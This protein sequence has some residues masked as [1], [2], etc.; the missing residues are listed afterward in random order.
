MGTVR[1]LAA[2]TLASVLTVASIGLSNAGAGPFSWAARD[3]NVQAAIFAKALEA[4][5]PEIHLARSAR[6]I[7][8]TARDEG[9]EGAETVEG[10]AKN[11]DID[12]IIKEMKN[13]MS[14]QKPAVYKGSRGN[15]V[16][17]Y[18]NLFFHDKGRFV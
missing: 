4:A 6:I 13:T 3:P 12:L 1:M 10:V 16:P 15:Y 11:R 8:E 14:E 17:S 9:L 7:R 5:M 2:T 18:L